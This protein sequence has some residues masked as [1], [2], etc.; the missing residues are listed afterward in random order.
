M[1]LGADGAINGAEQ[2]T[3]KVLEEL[4]FKRV[5]RYRHI[6]PM[7]IEAVASG[8]VNLKGIITDVFDFNDIQNAMDKSVQDKD[9]IVKAV[10]H[11]SE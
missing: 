4:I 2:N 1:Q 7:A 8:K 11:I 5:F 10:V 9:N 3:V 6:Y